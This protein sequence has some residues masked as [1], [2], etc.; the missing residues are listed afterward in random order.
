[1]LPCG[2]PVVLAISLECFLCVE[3]YMLLS[4]S[5]VAFYPVMGSTSYSII[6]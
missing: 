2:T 3:V 5:Q 1:M 4:V 6:I